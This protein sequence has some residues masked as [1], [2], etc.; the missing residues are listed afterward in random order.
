M[1][2]DFFKVNGEAEASLI[3]VDA[4]GVVRVRR[5]GE[6]PLAQLLDGVLLVPGYDYSERAVGT[7]AASVALHERADTVF[8]GPSTTRRS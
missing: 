8:A 2:D 6:G 1:F 3:M 5:D 7:T 4:A